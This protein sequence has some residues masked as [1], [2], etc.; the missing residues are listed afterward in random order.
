MAI[1]RFFAQVPCLRFCTLLFNLFFS[2]YT[3]F[4]LKA[5]LFSLILSIFIVVLIFLLHGYR[6][7][8]QFREHKLQEQWQLYCLTLDNFYQKNNSGLTLQTPWNKPQKKI[9]FYHLLIQTLKHLDNVALKAAMTHAFGHSGN[10]AVLEHWLACGNYSQKLTAIEGLSCLGIDTC[11]IQ[12]RLV[13]LLRDPC[14]VLSL[15]AAEA[16]MD[17]YPQQSLYTILDVYRDRTDWAENHV[18]TLLFKQNKDSVQLMICHLQQCFLSG[19]IVPVEWLQLLQSQIPSRYDLICLK[20]LMLQVIGLSW[21]VDVQLAALSVLVSC[22]L[23]V[24]ADVIFR[25][26]HHQDWRFRL[27]AL[28]LASTQ[29]QHFQQKLFQEALEDSSYWISS[30]AL[31]SLQSLQEKTV[32]P[33][34]QNQNMPVSSIV[35]GSGGQY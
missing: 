18:S 32:L 11:I 21:R 5:A 17:S 16:L 13:G 8:R 7:L 26:Q 31:L 22:R 29:T 34:Q 10:V 4:F 27:K 3:H 20:R 33:G 23:T 24:P 19:G 15:K 12:T 1:H 6:A 30:Q 25:Y 35:S 28:Q 2:P 9:Q 14:P